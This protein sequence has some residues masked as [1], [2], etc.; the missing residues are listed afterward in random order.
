MPKKAQE[1]TKPE[2]APEELPELKVP[3]VLSPLQGFTDFVREQG[4]VGLAVGLVLGT[5]VKVLVDQIIKS[6]IDPMLGLLLPGGGNL[7]D[8]VFHLNL[9][10]KGA[11]FAWGAFA[12]Q[13]ISFIVVA[14]VIYTIVHRLKLDRLDKKKA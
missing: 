6:F 10:G 13:L 2:N 12:S 4:V 9:L 3:G 1:V 8:K 7:P 14:F 11:D 5:Q